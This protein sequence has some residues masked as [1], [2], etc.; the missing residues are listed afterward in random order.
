MVA[1]TLLSSSLSLSAR[2]YVPTFFLDEREGLLVLGRPWHAAPRQAA[3]QGQRC[4]P[5][6]SCLVGC[7]CSWSSGGPCWGPW[8]GGSTEP[9][10]LLFNGCCGRW[11][12]SITD[13]IFFPTFQQKIRA[14]SLKF[15][16]FSRITLVIQI[17]ITTDLSCD[18]NGTLC[19][20]SI[21]YCSVLHTNKWSSPNLFF[22]VFP[23]HMPFPMWPLTWITAIFQ[24]KLKTSWS[25]SLLPHLTMTL[26]VSDSAAF[27]S[28]PHGSGSEQ[29]SCFVF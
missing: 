1:G 26:S 20:F 16:V 13:V 7:S 17:L 2:M 24:D 9:E 27:T 10:S 29:A 23:M 6:A 19:F 3:P 18:L 14:V 5:S 12:S 15:L 4:T 28:A 25:V 21:F 11:A 22:I 8:L